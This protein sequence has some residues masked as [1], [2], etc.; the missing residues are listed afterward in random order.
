MSL[1]ARRGSLRLFS[2]P[3]TALWTSPNLLMQ[4][5]PARAF[6]V[7]AA[8]DFAPAADGETAGLVVFGRDYAWIGLRRTPAGMRVV[9]TL[10]MHADQGGAEREIASHDVAAQAIQL[11]VAVDAD[12]TCRFAYSVDGRT[13]TAL[14]PGFAARQGIWVG[15]KAGL[16]AV[17]TPAASTGHADW[18]WVRV[19]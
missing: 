18:D 5:W 15:A 3:A 13:F 11:R 1:T 9:M 12:A 17:S 6:T 2:Q 14:G 19:K 8:L 7:D 4:K 10:A 16:F